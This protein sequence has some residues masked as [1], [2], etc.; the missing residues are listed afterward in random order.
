M[1]DRIHKYCIGLLVFLLVS[2]AIY[3]AD[4]H[5][6]VA[7]DGSS[8]FRTVQEAI[9]AVPDFRKNETR[10]F[11]RNGTYKE[12]LVL[13]GSKTNVTFIGENRDK[14]IL[15]FDD[16]ASKKNRFAEEIGTTGSTSFFVFGDDFRAEN[17]TFEN[18]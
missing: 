8:D 1:L 7:A 2:S 12:K 9:N 5:F 10:I 4:Y 17:I 18:S 15:T 11:I 6:V 16:F 3:A 13:A 14:T